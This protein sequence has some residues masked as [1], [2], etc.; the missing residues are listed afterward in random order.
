MCQSSLSRARDN[1]SLPWSRLSIRSLPNGREFF[2]T[3][4]I[5]SLIL[6]TFPHT[7]FSGHIVSPN[8]PNIA[9]STNVW[10][11]LFC[12]PVIFSSKVVPLVHGGWNCEVKAMFSPARERFSHERGFWKSPGREK[13]PGRGTFFEVPLTVWA[14]QET[15]YW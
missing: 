6:V 10:K 12:T 2:C 3:D 11:W 8:V 15:M 4:A 7:Q 14:A 9:L 5:T 13:S 1:V